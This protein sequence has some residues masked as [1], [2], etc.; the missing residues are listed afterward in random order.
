MNTKSAVILAAAAATVAA[1]SA[2]QKKQL[3]IILQDVGANIN[4]YINLVS[5]PSSGITFDNLPAGLIDIG[6]EVAVDPKDTSYTSEYDNVDIA[7]VSLFV[8]K[9]SW[10]SDRLAPKLD[11]AGVP[12]AAE[13]K[14]T[15]AVETTKAAETTAAAT[16]AA[17]ATSAAA[18]TTKAAE[19]SA[20]A[21]E[22]SAAPATSAAATTSK[23]AEQTTKATST[24]AQAIS[25][26][27]DGQIQATAS[28]HQQT[29][30]AAAK[31]VAGLGAGAMAAV[32]LLL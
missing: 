6:E 19:T 28:V 2:D 5:D 4:E 31:A 7:G 20:K 32:A 30:N 1:V 18:E 11:A 25:Q 9:L 24:V 12:I 16:S 8:T 23:A 15:S 10:Y 27:G 3:D 13:A 14:K 29:E 21:E 22:T 17:P 26:I